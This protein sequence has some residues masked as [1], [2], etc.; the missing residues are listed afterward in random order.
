MEIIYDPKSNYFE[1]N[2]FIHKQ[3]ASTDNI[4]QSV[5][6]VLYTSV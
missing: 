4:Q 2:N 3:A 6:T 5:V 1:Q